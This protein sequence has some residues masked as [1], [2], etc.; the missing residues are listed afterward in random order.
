VEPDLQLNRLQG[1][2]LHQSSAPAQGWVSGLAAPQGVELQ[3]EVGITGGCKGGHPHSGGWS[4]SDA[5]V[6]VA[7]RREDVWFWVAGHHAVE[8]WMGSRNKFKKKKALKS[9][10]FDLNSVCW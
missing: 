9:G 4:P 2:A 7:L 6:L 3:L 10:I 8:R 1:C 5:A